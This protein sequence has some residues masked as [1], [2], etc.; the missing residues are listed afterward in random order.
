[1]PLTRDLEHVKAKKSAL[2]NKVKN[3][4]GHNAL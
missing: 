4:G 2:S 3:G 1:M